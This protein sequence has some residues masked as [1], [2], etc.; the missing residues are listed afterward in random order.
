MGGS[1]IPMPSRRYVQLANSLYIGRSVGGAVAQALFTP[2]GLY[3]VT[4]VKNLTFDTSVARG[5]GH[6]GERDPRADHRRQ[7]RHRVRLLPERYHLVADDDQA[8]RIDQPA[9]ARSTLVHAGG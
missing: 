4:G 2:E 7:Q 6:P 3:P 8:R 9:H 5:G 1:G